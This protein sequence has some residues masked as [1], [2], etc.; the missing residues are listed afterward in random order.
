MPVMSEAS[1]TSPIAES[2]A[3]TGNDRPS[4]EE[5][6]ARSEVARIAGLVRAGLSDLPAEIEPAHFAA[7]FAALADRQ[8]SDDDAG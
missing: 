3:G 8:G 2:A 7:V 4:L 6:R 5:A 1:P